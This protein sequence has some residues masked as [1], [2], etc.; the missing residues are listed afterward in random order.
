MEQKGVTTGKINPDQCV[1]SRVK[2]RGLSTGLSRRSG[3]NVPSSKLSLGGAWGKMGA[4]QP[5]LLHNLRPNPALHQTPK[6][7]VEMTNASVTSASMMGEDR[8]R[9]DLELLDMLSPVSTRC[10]TGTPP[11]LDSAAQHADVP[12]AGTSNPKPQST[13]FS[14]T[15]RRPGLPGRGGFKR[16]RLADPSKNSTS[17]TIPSRP[18]TQHASSVIPFS[19]A[20]SADSSVSRP[21]Q[22]RPEEVG[23]QVSVR[24]PLGWIP[25]AFPERGQKRSHGVLL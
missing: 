21:S 8:P 22:L 15:I 13:S 17:S 3:V 14:S 5:N 12:L 11:V 9:S 20:P 25:I 7:Q 18:P 4:A 16:P 24:H 2:P 23:Q 1:P 19:C 6:V 10:S